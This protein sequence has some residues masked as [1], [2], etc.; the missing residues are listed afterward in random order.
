MWLL[1]LLTAVPRELLGAALNCSMAV[2][3]DVQR[4]PVGVIPHHLTQLQAR[5]LLAACAFWAVAATM[6][7][8][9]LL[10]L[11]VLIVPMWSAA[12]V[13]FWISWH[14]IYRR[15]NQQPVHHCPP[16]HV[17]PREVFDRFIWD[18]EA[19]S[20]YIDI[21]QMISKWHWDVPVSELTRGNV[22]D[23]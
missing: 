9:S 23:L 21:N 18:Q 4:K 15:L 1:R 19:I 16:P 3:S 17:N 2:K 12:E 6:A 11:G 8:P 10:I 5:C 7:L 13:V 22:A 20:K 14:I